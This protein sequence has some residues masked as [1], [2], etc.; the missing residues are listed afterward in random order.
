MLYFWY[1][2]ELNLDSWIIRVLRNLP[3][4][5]K[6]LLDHWKSLWSQSLG[7]S[8]AKLGNVCLLAPVT[9]P[10]SVAASASGPGHA[11]HIWHPC[12]RAVVRNEQLRIR[13]KFVWIMALP[14]IHKLCDLGKCISPPCTSFS[15]SMLPNHARLNGTL[16][17]T[18]KHL[19]YGE[20]S[21]GYPG[22]PSHSSLFPEWT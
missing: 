10:S 15:L 19:V 4:P 6:L 13:K 5:S 7:S 22:L 2:S 12:H 8:L 3:D 1:S 14:L 17:H 11:R 21:L 16:H 9:S 20:R 18:A